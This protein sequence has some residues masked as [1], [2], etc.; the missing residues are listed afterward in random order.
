MSNLW[1]ELFRIE[2]DSLQKGVDSSK[3]FAEYYHVNLGYKR[4][5]QLLSIAPVLISVLVVQ[6]LIGSP[7]ELE[8]SLAVVLVATLPRT[9]YIFQS[10]YSFTSYLSYYVL[11][12]RKV[13]NLYDFPES[14]DIS[15]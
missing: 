9:M 12:K 11:M 13:A 6:L 10:I 4:F 7:S 8:A 5:E 15:D 14:L 3:L 2:N 1:P